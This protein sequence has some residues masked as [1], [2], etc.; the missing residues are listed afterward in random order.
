MERGAVAIGVV[1]AKFE[2]R[3]S[4]ACPFER[5][6]RC[7]AFI[8]VILEYHRDWIAKLLY[9]SLSVTRSLPEIKCYCFLESKRKSTD[10]GVAIFG[11]KRGCVAED[12]VD[13]L[14]YVLL[15]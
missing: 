6:W 13:V 5:N 1:E 2:D 14:R 10:V 4:A 3:I 7:C 15:L 8:V 9:H 12:L 11:V